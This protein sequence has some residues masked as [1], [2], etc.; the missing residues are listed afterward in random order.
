MPRSPLPPTG[1]IGKERAEGTPF[2]AHLS[3]GGYF[4]AV[5]VVGKSQQITLSDSFLC[6]WLF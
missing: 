5:P 2:H 4:S 1:L 3:R 6:K